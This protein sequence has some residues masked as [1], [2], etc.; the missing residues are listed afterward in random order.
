[1]RA[2]K[3][4]ILKQADIGPGYKLT[5]YQPTAQS[6]QDDA[7]L[8]HCI[9]RP[10]SPVHQ[11]AKLF[12]KQFS[13]GDSL[14]ILASITFVD[15]EQTAQEDVTALRGPRAE[16]C[17]KQSFLDQ[18]KRAGEQASVDVTN[19]SPSPTGSAPAANYRIKIFARIN[20]G[21]IP[22]FL[23]I[24]QAIKGR[25][26]VSVSFQN[27]NQPVPASIERRAMSAMLGRL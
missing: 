12:S 18:S 5:Q 6:E 26:E 14:I 8:N 13:R 23:D 1:M 7:A 25:A 3:D 27:V 24:V 17:I 21:T 15:T 4:A 10:P 2:A 16:S 11:T 22:E 9:G 19:L 20:G